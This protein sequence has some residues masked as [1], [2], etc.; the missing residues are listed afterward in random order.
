MPPPRPII[1]IHSAAH[2]CAAAAAAAALNRPVLLR[3]AADAAGYAGAAWFDEVIKLARTRHP[4][5]DIVASLDCGDAPG[6]ALA[7]LRQ[8]VDMVRLRA[9]PAVVAKVAAIARRAG[10]ALDEQRGPALDL[11]DERDAESACRRWLSG[12]PPRGSPVTEK[13]RRNRL[14]RNRSGC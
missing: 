9:R 14:L 5:A 8:G 2:A 7:A 4:A 12:A 6:F 3:S 11:L 1:V 13:S 10:A